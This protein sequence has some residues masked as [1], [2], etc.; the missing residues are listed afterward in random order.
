MAIFLYSVCAR[1]CIAPGGEQ[2]PGFLTPPLFYFKTKDLILTFLLQFK[3]I[4]FYRC[5]FDLT[6]L[7]VLFFMLGYRVLL[8]NLNIRG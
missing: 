4:T 7:P 6:F 3:N 2:G 5:F 8:M 1:T